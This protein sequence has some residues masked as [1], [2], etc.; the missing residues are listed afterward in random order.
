MSHFE[1][2]LTLY[3]PLLSMTYGWNKRG[4]KSMSYG[5]TKVPNA[6]I[7]AVLNEKTIL[8][9]TYMKYYFYVASFLLFVFMVSV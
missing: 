9:K 8:G 1:H 5:L 3:F 6:V 2:S 7:I 4:L